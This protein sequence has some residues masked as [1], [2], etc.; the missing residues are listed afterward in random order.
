M[1][2]Q[3]VNVVIIINNKNYGNNREIKFFCYCERT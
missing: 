2:K 1:S 3:N